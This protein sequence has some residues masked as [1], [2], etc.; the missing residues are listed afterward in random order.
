MTNQKTPVQGCTTCGHPESAHKIVSDLCVKTNCRCEMFVQLDLDEL[1][2]LADAATPGPWER[3]ETVHTDNY[4][5]AGGGVLTGTHVCGPTYERH[6]ALFIAAA[7]EAVPALITRVRELEAALSVS[8]SADPAD[9]HH[10]AEERQAESELCRDCGDKMEYVGTPDG[11]SGYLHCWR[12]WYLEHPQAESEDHAATVTGD[13]AWVDRQLANEVAAKMGVSAVE[14][15][16][17]AVRKIV[18]EWGSALYTMEETVDRLCAALAAPVE[19]DEAKLAEAK[20]TVDSVHQIH[21]NECL[22]GFASHRSRSRT[23][24]I[25]DA[26]ASA[27]RGEGR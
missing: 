5:T 24:H 22:C 12:C 19:V 11:A 1:H 2:R 7:R 6:N 27:L 16:R 9:E 15:Q 4:V 18:S 13:D 10:N 3:Q 26:L 20:Y 8:A 17:M 23:E 14:L 21:G 25:T